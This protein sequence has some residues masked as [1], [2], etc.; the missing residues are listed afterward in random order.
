MKQFI[1]SKVASLQA[2]SGQLYQQMNSFT[3]IFPRFYLDFK[4]H[5][6]PHVLTQASPSNF[7]DSP[8]PPF[9]PP[10]SQH[11]WETLHSRFQGQPKLPD[12]SKKYF[13]TM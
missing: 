6:P 4:N 2:Y 5:S 10:C 8:P 9:L 3:G 12:T 7:E 1:L 13:R 11:L